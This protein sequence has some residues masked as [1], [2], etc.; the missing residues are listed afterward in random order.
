MIDQYLL[1]KWKVTAWFT[2]SL[3]FI[4]PQRGID[5]I[6][7]VIAKY[8][9]GVLG[10]VNATIK[11]KY[12]NL[13]QNP[14][15]TIHGFEIIVF[16]ITINFLSKHEILALG[17]YELNG[18]LIFLSIFLLLPALF[19]LRNLADLLIWICI[20]LPIQLFFFFLTRCPKGSV[21][22]LGITMQ[23]IILFFEKPDIH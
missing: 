11:E 23:I 8:S 9:L 5:F 1:W 18:F 16:A 3:E 2:M 10:R 6:N 22:A 7:R 21:L 20:A 17:S 13:I 19:L 15:K 14:K 4:L 12:E